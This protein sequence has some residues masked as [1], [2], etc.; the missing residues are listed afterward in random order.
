MNVLHQSS[1][2]LSSKLNTYDFSLTALNGLNV[3]I[4]LLFYKREDVYD[5]IKDFIRLLILKSEQKK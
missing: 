1:H 4:S 5:K 3:N 2:K